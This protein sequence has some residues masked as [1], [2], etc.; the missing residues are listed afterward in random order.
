MLEYD[1]MIKATDGAT[2]TTFQTLATKLSE[3]IVANGYDPKTKGMR[4][5]VGFTHCEPPG[6]APGWDSVTLLSSPQFDWTVLGCQH[7]NSLVGG[8]V[9]AA[10][11]LSAEAQTAMRIYYDADP[12][13]PRRVFGDQFYAALY[14]KSALTVPLLP[15]DDGYVNPY[16]DTGL[17]AGKWFGFHFGVGMAHQWPAVRLG[18]VT[19]KTTTA[20]PIQARLGNFANAVDIVIDY[21]AADGTVTPSSPCT[22]AACTFDTDDRQNYLYRV[23]YRK[24]GGITIATGRYKPVN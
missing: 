24:S 3:W 8:A 11:A 16:I 1:W 12:T 21:L 2:R 20:K 7:G 22:S 17:N 9:A 15:T 14:G 13:T 6:T 4:Y 5:G 10:R 18:G 19:P 23:R